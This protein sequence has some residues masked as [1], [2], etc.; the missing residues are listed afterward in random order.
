M[1]N[2][3]TIKT[4]ILALAAT[5]FFTLSAFATKKPIDT[6]KSNIVW[7]GKKV[8]GQH[9]GDIKFKSGNVILDAGKLVG[10]TFTVDMTTINVLDLEGGKKAYLEKH[11]KGEDFF[12][13]KE[14]AEAVFTITSV[15]GNVVEGDLTVKGHTDKETFTL[16]LEDHTISGTIK[17]NRTKYGITYKSATFFEKIKDKAIN[18]DFELSLEIVY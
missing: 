13:V 1:M 3:K 17:V 6:S 15:K 14:F 7:I 8:G 10:G 9:D 11:L 16:V 12:G 18:D 2:A 5:V 4:T